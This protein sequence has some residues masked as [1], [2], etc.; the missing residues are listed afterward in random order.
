MK[1]LI[2]DLDNTLFDTRSCNPYL[3]T[4]AGRSAIVSALKSGALNITAVDSRIIEY[5]NRLIEAKA[6]E[7]YVF[8]DSP[9]EY[10][11]CLVDM[12]SLNISSDN[13]FGAQHKP[14]VEPNPIFAKH[15]DILIIGDSPKDIFFG[16]IKK[17]P[18][19]FFTPLTEFDVEYVVSNSLPTK[20]ARNLNELSDV[21]ADFYKGL[22]SY[23]AIDLQPYFKTTSAKNARLHIINVGDIGYSREYLPDTSTWRNDTDK[24]TWFDVRRIIKPSKELSHEQLVNNEELK[25]YNKNGSIGTSGYLERVAFHYMTNFV[26]W[27]NEKNITGEVYLIPV[28]SSV[29]SECN[30]SFPMRQ[31]A[32]WWQNWCS[33]KKRRGEVAFEL[34]EYSCVERYWPSIPSHL[35]IGQRHVEPHFDS[36]GVFKDTKQIDAVGSIVVILDDVV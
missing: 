8:S 4:N 19:V 20:V 24:Y 34:K 1:A 21:I 7:V 25:F 13:I 29:P 3:R 17:L 5:I 16:H 15:E 35:S 12:F 10:C 9:K 6:F 26:S 33:K 2:F 28:P 36:L 11:K 22:F 32:V 23:V 31:V 18:T 14:I 27:L 30:K